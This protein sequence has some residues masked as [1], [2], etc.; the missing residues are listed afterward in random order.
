MF[1]TGNSFITFTTTITL[2]KLYEVN[3][4]KIDES[5]HWCHFVLKEFISRYTVNFLKHRERNS[6]RR[7]GVCVC[8][9]GGW[10]GYILRHSSCTSLSVVQS[11]LR[12]ILEEA[13]NH[14]RFMRSFIP[15]DVLRP[16]R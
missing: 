1:S 2:H 11:V 8:V 6:V 3:T 9:A 7:V 14:G 10:R 16:V 15:C 4:P 5:G 12:I 13:T